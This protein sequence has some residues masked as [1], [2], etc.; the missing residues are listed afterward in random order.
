MNLKK[1]AK[2]T[3]FALIAFI[4]LAVVVVKKL[5]YSTPIPASNEKEKAYDKKRAEEWEKEKK[6]IESIK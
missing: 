3:F 1:A 4:A 6:R 5:G 2:Y